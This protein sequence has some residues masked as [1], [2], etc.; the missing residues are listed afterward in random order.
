[1][2]GEEFDLLELLR[3]EADPERVEGLMKA[4]ELDL[5]GLRDEAKRH[6]LKQVVEM[7]NLE[8]GRYAAGTKITDQMIDELTENAIDTHIHGG[9]DPFERRQLE[10]DIAID[11]TKARM[12]AI[13]IKTW[14][15]PSAS[16]NQ[17]LRKIVDRWAEEHQMRPVQIFGGVTLNSSQGGLNPEAVLKCLGFPGFQYVWMPMADAYYHQW[18]VFNKKNTGIKFLTDD[19]K[20]LP[21]MQ[22]ILRIVADN[23]LILA[24]GHYPYRETAILMEEAKRLGVKRMEVVHPTLIHSKHTIAQMKEM[25]SEGVKLGLTGIATLNVWFLEGIQLILRVVKELSD[26]LVWGSDSGQIQNPTH[27]EGMKWMIRILLAYGVA[28]EEITK[29]FKTNPAVHLAIG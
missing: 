24:S 7:M 13:V 28:K 5:P 16:R 27:I 25:A 20:V 12:K 26:H 8:Y 11:A 9:S 29:I 6:L 23:N 15:T 2:A 17:L 1:M 18:L 19:G 10:D 14:Y 4:V 3:L 21:Q 22:D